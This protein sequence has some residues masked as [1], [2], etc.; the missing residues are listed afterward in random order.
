M[1]S[2]PSVTLP[3]KGSNQRAATTTVAKEMKIPPSFLAKI[4]SQLS[5]AGLLHTS[6]RRTRRRYPGTRAEG[7]FPAGCGRSHR[8]ADPAQR[9][10]WHQKPCAFED[11]CLVHP[12]WVEVQ[13]SLVKRLRDHPLRRSLFLTQPSAFPPSGAIWAASGIQP[14]LLITD[15]PEYPSLRII[16]GREFFSINRR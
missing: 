12:I 11:D 4:I 16:A 9:M 15:S 7:N 5:I 10:C 1:P 14:Y 3:S 8:W 6:P 13:E 2:A